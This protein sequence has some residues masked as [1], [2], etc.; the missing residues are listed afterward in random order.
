[1]DYIIEILGPLLQGTAVTLQVFLLTL[2]LSVRWGWALR[3]CAFR[4]F[5]WPAR[6]SMATSG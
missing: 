1:M 3:W 2:L 5:T 4:A 6:W